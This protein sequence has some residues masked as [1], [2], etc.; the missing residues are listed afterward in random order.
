MP[1]REDGLPIGL[2]MPLL[3]EAVRDAIPSPAEGAMITC[4]NPGS[5]L[6]V[7]AQTVPE[8]Q[9]Y[10]APPGDPIAAPNVNPTWQTLVTAVRSNPD[11]LPNPLQ[12]GLG[13]P[14][15]DMT[16]VAGGNVFPASLGL[17]V[18]S[19]VA[20]APFLA[21]TVYVSTALAGLATDWT[22]L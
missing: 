1:A 9:V 11:A 10:T 8:V 7:P 22:A 5:S 12:G 20:I 17:L 13:L 4:R 14:K 19:T 6:T 21:D 18:Y 15:V 2:V 16:P 3:T